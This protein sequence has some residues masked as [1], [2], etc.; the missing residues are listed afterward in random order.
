LKTFP[1]KWRLLF[2]NVELS[3]IFEDFFREIEAF[4]RIVRL[5]KYVFSGIEAFCN[6]SVAFIKPNAAEAFYPSSPLK[7]EV[8]RFKKIDY[9]QQNR[10]FF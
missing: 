2:R 10:S 4:S 3:I 7:V 1:E 5:F 8:P 9:A 6:F